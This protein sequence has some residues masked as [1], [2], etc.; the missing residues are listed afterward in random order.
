[1]EMSNEETSL[2]SFHAL[3]HPLRK[4]RNQDS[5]RDSLDDPYEGRRPNKMNRSK[6][7]R[8]KPSYAAFEEIPEDETEENENGIEIK[9]N[10]VQNSLVN[11]Y[12][13]KGDP[14]SDKTDSV[15]RSK[16]L[17]VKDVRGSLNRPL[18]LDSSKEE[19]SKQES[20]VNMSVK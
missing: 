3:R 7:S 1:M 17:S 20:S 13:N 19:L 8:H 4:S 5:L 15:K 2:G 10:S 14:Q 12:R 9:E 11:S 16:D 18:L 6:R